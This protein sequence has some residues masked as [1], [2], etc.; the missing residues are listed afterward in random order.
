MICFEFTF[1]ARRTIQQAPN[2]AETRRADGHGLRR[3]GFTQTEGMSL[4]E[5]N[6][7]AADHRNDKRRNGR[8]RMASRDLFPRTSHRNR[9]CTLAEAVEVGFA[10]AFR[11]P[12]H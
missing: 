3:A 12:L 5:C 4:L 11:D 10:K 8:N 6:G 9:Q 1:Q 2:P 7:E